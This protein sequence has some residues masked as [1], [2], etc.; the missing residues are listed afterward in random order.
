MAAG[1]PARMAGTQR[2]DDGPPVLACSAERCRSGAHAVTGAD[3]RPQ[4]GLVRTV[5][6]AA[7]GNVAS[8][9]AALVTA[10]VLARSLG[11]ADRGHLAAASA[12]L[13]LLSVAATVGLPEALTYTVARQPELTRACR[14][15]AVLGIVAGGALSAVVCLSLAN[16]LSQGDAR[17]ATLIRLSSIAVVPALLVALLRGTAMGLNRWRMVNTD[18]Y[19]NAGFRL[20]GIVGLAVTGRLTTTSAFAVIALAPVIAGCAY[21][22]ILRGIG[23]PP[24]SAQMTGPLIRYASRVWLGSI[25]GVAFSRLDQVLMTP[26]STP[27]QLGLYVAAVNVADALL[28]GSTAVVN[29]MFAADARDPQQARLQRAA[30]LAGL[31]GLSVAVVLGVLLHWLV[32][33]LFGREFVG[34][35]PAA[36]VLL[37][38]TALGFPGSVAGAGLQ[39]RGR[40]GLRGVSLA[41][42]A[43]CN[44]VLLVILVPRLGALGA[45]LATLAGSLLAANLNIYFLHRTAGFTIKGFYLV[46][47]DDLR[48]VARL[49][50]RRVSGAR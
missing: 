29:V 18:K 13:L 12:L 43:V 19:L 48:R 27:F 28:I 17:V 46:R 23:S 24:A 39:A 30:R 25:A 50:L 36:W 7:V 3:P 2:Y 35:L 37:A 4:Q 22:G 32:P 8:P 21:T 34:L 15:P 47:V 11:V 16:T 9:V 44:I 41:V 26:L 42:A 1:G 20:V 14:R 45:A 38:A 31:G 33:L 49:L 40:P 6:S 10:P 5:L